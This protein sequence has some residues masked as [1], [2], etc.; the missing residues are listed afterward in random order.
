MKLFLIIV[1]WASLFFLVPARADTARI[2]D[3]L[4]ARGD[5]API[6]DAAAARHHVSALRLAVLLKSENTRCQENA[7][8]VTTHAAG[9]FGILP[10][11][12]ANPAHLEPAELLD[13]ETNTDLGAAHLA[14]LLRLCGTFAGALHVYHSKDGK[15]R[16]W[17]TDSHVKRVLGIERALI[18]WLRS[19]GRAGRQS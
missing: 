3:H 10:T 8:N 4:C 1:A 6:V 18:R 14:N 2:L 16:N 15:C 11:G 5:L 17:R 19:S 13:A 7:V 9:L 12:S